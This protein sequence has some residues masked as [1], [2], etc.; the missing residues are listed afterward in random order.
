MD[1]HI[2][3]T[4]P[5]TSFMRESHTAEMNKDLCFSTITHDEHRFPKKNR[6]WKSKLLYWQVL[7]RIIENIC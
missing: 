3:D 6:K 4:S 1:K 5:W 2:D 7:Y